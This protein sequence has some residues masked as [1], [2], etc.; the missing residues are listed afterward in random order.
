VNKYLSKI[1]GKSLLDQIRVEKLEE[2][3]RLLKEES[4]RKKQLEIEKEKRK[5]QSRLVQNLSNKSSTKLSSN[6]NVQHKQ[7]DLN[8]KKNFSLENLQRPAFMTTPFMS[9]RKG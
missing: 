6:I 5:H 7:D 9:Y 3:N 1:Y 4:E 2:K 8:T